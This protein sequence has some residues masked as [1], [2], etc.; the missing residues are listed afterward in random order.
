MIMERPSGSL[1]FFAGDFHCSLAWSAAGIRRFGFRRRRSA[2]RAGAAGAGSTPPPFVQAARRELEKYFAGGEP[3]FSAVP[4]DLAGC[5]DFSRAVYRAVGRIPY[6]RTLSY[7]DV[8]ER[9]GNRKAARAVG[10]CMKRNPVPILI[11]CHRVIRGDGRAGGFTSPGGAGM[12]V[13]LLR[14]EGAGR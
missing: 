2:R 13:R 14:M 5:G 1:E 9:A 12:K 10:M 8:A 7:A 11:P 4:L 3:D 6:G